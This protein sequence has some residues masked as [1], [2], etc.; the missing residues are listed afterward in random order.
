MGAEQLVEL[1]TFSTGRG[2]AWRAQLR[3]S[4]MTLAMLLVTLVVTL[5]TRFGNNIELDRWLAFVDFRVVGD[6]LYFLPPGH[7]LTQAWRLF[8]PMLLHFGVLHL[9]MN[10]LW[11]WELGRRIEYRH[12]GW[13][14]LG[15]TLV[16]SLASN[17]VQYRY[18]GP[19]LFG[20]LS[21]VLYGLLGYCWI[22]QKFAPHPAVALPTAVV[23][24]MLVW[25]LICLTGAMGTLG[26]GQ[27]ANGAHVGG[28]VA[29]C[30]AGALVGLFARARR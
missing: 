14:L 6:Q 30:L 12:N 8:S 16:F 15:L 20:G 29:G 10:G 23:A 28:L 18:F 7:N 17:I 19:A 13:V 3:A 1:P 9:A 25:L 26:L 2:A 5:L 21:G 11:Y 27:I 24:M 4:P 22:L